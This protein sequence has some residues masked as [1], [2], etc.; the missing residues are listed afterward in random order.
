MPRSTGDVR[1]AYDETVSTLAC[2]KTPPRWVPCQIDLAELV[3]LDAGNAV[4]LGQALIQEG[5]I[6]VDEIED[7]AVFADDVLEEQVGLLLHRHPRVVGEF[8]ELDAV[9][10][11]R[12]QGPR[13]QPLAAEVFDQGVAPWRP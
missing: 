10:R 9:G 13:L 4:K 5:V 1:L 7:G 6:G 3:P 12:F 8:R 2:V 11:V